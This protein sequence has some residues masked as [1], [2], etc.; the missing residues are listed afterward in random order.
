MQKMKSGLMM[1]CLTVLLSCAALMMN[2][3]TA[4][5]MSLRD[6]CGDYR[7]TDAYPAGHSQGTIISFTIENGEF[8]G[9]VKKAASGVAWNP[10]D[11]YMKDVYVDNGKMHC[12]ILREDVWYSACPV[13]VSSNGA[14]IQVID[15][16]MNHA[17]YELHR[18]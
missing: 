1:V 18:L 8:I 9:R 12:Q 6:L 14:T 7:I 4:S 11:I 13:N 16:M 5:A 10:G 17:I 3:P 15:T 2:M